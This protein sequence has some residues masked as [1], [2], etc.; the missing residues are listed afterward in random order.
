MIN[1]RKVYRLPFSKIYTNPKMFVRLVDVM[2]RV[3]DDDF[4]TLNCDNGL[5]YLDSHIYS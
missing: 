2:P 4:V 5:K 1:L 3:S